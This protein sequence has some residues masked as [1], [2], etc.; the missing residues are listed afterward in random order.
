VRD[1]FGVPSEQR[2]NVTVTSSPA[3]IGDIDR[4][5]TTQGASWG[6]TVTL[7][8]HGENHAPLANVRVTGL[9]SNGTVGECFTSTDGRCAVQR[10]GLP[11]QTRTLSFSVTSMWG[12][13]GYRP[14]RNH[15]PDGDS[16]GT[17]IVVT[18]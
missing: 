15:D 10:G 16:N 7:T 1:N 12:A 5:V 6:T 8:A 9:W 4:V 2:T 18:R 17:T 13:A 11:K 3:H 14:E